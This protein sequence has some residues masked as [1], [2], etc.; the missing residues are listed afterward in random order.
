MRSIRILAVVV[1]AVVLALSAAQN[2][3]AA[4]WIFYDNGTYG[5]E[6]DSKLVGVRFSL[7]TGV[8]S[9]HLLTVKFYWAPPPDSV[10]GSGMV[11]SIQPAAFPDVTVHVT[12]SPPGTDLITPIDVP[13]AVGGWNTVDVS[14]SNLVVT[15]DFYVLIAQAVP[16]TVGYDNTG[17]NFEGRSVTGPTVAG[18]QVFS[19][20]LMIRAEIEPIVAP[21]GPVGGF[22]EPVNKLV[23]FA[24]YLALLGVIGAV[25]VVFRKRPQN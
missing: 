20:S 1:L 5:G 9:A 7:P 18:L 8:S 2:A 25:A 13:T 12:G 15:G 16:D 23:V 4:Q 10:Q 21:V 11:M 17:S 24:P 22:V 14:G 6:N 3:F 19:R